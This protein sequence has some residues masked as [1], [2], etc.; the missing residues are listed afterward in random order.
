V[1]DTQRELFE[2]KTVSLSEAEKLPLA[3]VMVRQGINGFYGK[4]GG[5]A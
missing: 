5:R 1:S 4:I 3:E 2:E